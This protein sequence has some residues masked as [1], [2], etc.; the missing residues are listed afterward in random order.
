MQDRAIISTATS[1]HVAARYLGA[2]YQIC[3]FLRN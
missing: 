3:D 1:D 2:L